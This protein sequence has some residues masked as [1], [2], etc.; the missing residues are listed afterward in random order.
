[1]IFARIRDLRLV[2]V[3]RGGT[4]SDANHRLLAVWAAG[5]AAHVLHFFEDA[6]PG[7]E[8]PR[9]AI[10]LAH[11]W[12]QGEITMSPA[13]NSAGFANAAGMAADDED[14]HSALLQALIS[15]LLA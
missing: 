3:R 13:R 6:Q 15:W 1:M 9:R 7:D 14:G 5:C 4:L 8:R 10:A 11:A 12:V 2:T